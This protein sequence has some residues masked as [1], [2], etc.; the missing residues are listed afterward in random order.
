MGRWAPAQPHPVQST[1]PPGDAWPW[2]WQP[3]L[4]IPFHSLPSRLTPHSHSNYKTT[5]VSASPWKN[6]LVY[7]PPFVAF[8]WESL[9]DLFRFSGEVM[10]QPEPERMSP[11]PSPVLCLSATLWAPISMWL[12]RLCVLG[13]F[14]SA[15]GHQKGE[16]NLPPGPQ[17]SLTHT[18]FLHPQTRVLQGVSI[19]SPPPHSH[20]P[21]FLCPV[22][23]APSGRT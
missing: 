8:P 16:A 20:F 15:V 12:P 11:I 21:S 1:H 5:V 19:L 13:P 9:R 17:D 18:G 3:H 23:E 7:P 2:L 10:T 6:H 14:S 4:I 22:S